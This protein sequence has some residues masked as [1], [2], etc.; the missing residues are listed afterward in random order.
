[1]VLIIPFISNAYGANPNLYVSAENPLF[2]N[3]F[4]GSTVV[5]VVVKDPNLMKIDGLS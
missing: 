1:M 3:Y 4:S 5:E 2:N